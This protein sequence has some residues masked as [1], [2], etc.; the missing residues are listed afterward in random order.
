MARRGLAPS[1]CRV[2][3]FEEKAVEANVVVEIL[4]NT[5]KCPSKKTS[6]K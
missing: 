6:K 5:T 4:S 3:F 2:G 1:G